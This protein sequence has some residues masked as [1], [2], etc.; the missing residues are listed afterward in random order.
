[1][2]CIREAE[3]RLIHYRGLEKSLEQI[4]KDIARI[5]GRSTPSELNAVAMDVTGVRGG[6]TEDTLNVLYELK[7]LSESKKRTEEEIGSIAQTLKDISADKDSRIYG[8]ILYL[9]YVKRKD[10]DAMASELGYTVR[11][12]YRIK[13]EAIQKFAVQIF[14]IVALEAI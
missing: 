3:K 9:W 8:K 14:G 7:V 12:L 6:M 1:M 13:D 2:N 11:H 4:D 10:K 5:I